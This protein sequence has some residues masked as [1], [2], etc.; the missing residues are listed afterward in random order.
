MSATPTIAKTTLLLLPMQIVFRSIEALLPV[1][2]AIWFGRDEL[3]DVYYLSAAIFALAG[4]LVFSAFQDS[5]VVPIL[6]EVKLRDRGLLAA[7]R[8]S[9][10]AHTIVLGGALAVVV[11]ALAGGWFAW[12]YTA[13]ARTAAL[14]MAAPFGLYLLALSIK[15]FFAQMLNVERRYAGLPIASAVGAVTTIAAIAALRHRLSVVA[16]PCGLL[17]GELVAASVLGVLVRSAGIAITPTLRRPEP[18]RRFGRLVASEVGGAAVTRLNPVVDQLMA[19]LAGV[20]GGGTLLKL[21]ADVSTVPTSLLQAALL[22]VLLSHMSDDFATRDL[23]SLRSTVRRAVAGVVVILV[24]ASALL[25]AVRLP[26][27]R[28]VFAHGAMDGPGIER[29]AR[30]LPYHLVGLAPFGALLV[31][32]RAHVAAQNARIMVSMGVVNAALNA[33]LDLVFLAIFG[34]EGLALSTS[35]TY[36]VVAVL[37]AIR[38]E[39][40]L[41]AS[42]STPAPLELS[43]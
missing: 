42:A 14:E 4:S 36:A 19:R 13:S 29:M 32:V 1:A 38:L 25:W 22:P 3:T 15:T 16:V 31:L 41:T 28:L 40:H 34:L 26:L 2:I 8:G 11:A 37:L 33:G 21:S 12:R 43:P 6:A 7:V 10:L 35:C 18:V 23:V 20:L 27:L 30:I 9:L 24:A 39:W 5:S 17:A